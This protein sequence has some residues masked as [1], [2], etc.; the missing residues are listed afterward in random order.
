VEEDEGELSSLAVIDEDGVR[1]IVPMDE[2]IVKKE[3]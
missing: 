1:H 3:P 2:V